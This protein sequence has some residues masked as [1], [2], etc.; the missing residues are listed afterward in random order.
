M[1]PGFLTAVRRDTHTLGALHFAG[2]AVWLLAYP[3]AIC[4]LALKSTR[5]IAMIE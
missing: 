1:A 3:G 5:V 4:V 2:L